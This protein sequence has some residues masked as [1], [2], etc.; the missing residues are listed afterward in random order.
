MRWDKFDAL[1]RRLEGEARG[2][3]R[4]YK[5]RVLVWAL[6]GYAY[7]LFTLGV[8]FLFVVLFGYLTVYTRHPVAAAAL[9]VTFYLM[10][11]VA[12]SLRVVFL[13]PIGH[14]LKRSEAPF[15]FKAIDELRPKIRIPQI[16]CVMIDGQFNASASHIHRLRLSG[17][18]RNY[19]V[20]G[21]PLM[22]ALSPEHLRAVIIHELGH[23]SASQDKFSQWIYRVR[24]TWFRLIE[25][26][27][28]SRFQNE[29]FVRL[30][31][32]PFLKWY[33]DFFNAYSFVLLRS[34]EYE[35]DRF[36]AEFAGKR[37]A[38]E[39]LV[40][41][42][43]IERFLEI[44][45][46][47][48]VDKTA[49][50]RPEPPLDLYIQMEKAIRQ[51]PSPDEGKRLLKLV[52]SKKTYAADTHPSLQDRVSALGQDICLPPMPGESAAQYFLGGELSRISEKVGLIWRQFVMKWWLEKYTYF[53][54]AKRDLALLEEKSRTE[55]LSLEERWKEAY[56]SEDVK[57][58]DAAAE[59]YRKIVD[60][61]PEYLPAWFALGRILLMQN[62]EEG[63]GYL[64]H[65]MERDVVCVLDGY[66]LIYEYLINQGRAQDA[67]EYYN[68]IMRHQ[69][70]LAVA[71]E[72]RGSISSK[73]K[74][75]PH[76]LPEKEIEKIV[77]QLSRYPRIAEAYLVR[78]KLVYF[79]SNPLYV[80][81]ISLKRSWWKI[82]SSKNDRKFLEVIVKEV[83][84]PG[85]YYVVLLNFSPSAKSPMRASI[86]R[87]FQS[88]IYV[89]AVRG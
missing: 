63:L 11:M 43:V 74:F 80:L 34:F 86:T 1:V 2:K 59:L 65:A 28:N 20:L 35:A 50:I 17:W 41:I 19:L 49:F 18:N 3:P 71:Q 40:N 78:K 82:A 25:K 42:E 44:N 4:L 53:Q 21:L 56:L 69:D 8:L 76:G 75:I 77:A 67:D 60:S 70:D 73:D 26:L 89:D 48:E 61:D 14:E 9:L 13:P 81:G 16:H 84:L 36:V 72:E 85:E 58:V 10:Y 32:Q 7:V 22:M 27:K 5:F 30:F 54:E 33:P 68:R 6:L 47:K 23:F 62:K 45:F 39:T 29:W 79:E 15:L 55:L 66:G 38:A 12:S 51:G 64:K 83:S 37:I 52:L 88:Q 87:V 24:E 57:G 46:W 31:Y